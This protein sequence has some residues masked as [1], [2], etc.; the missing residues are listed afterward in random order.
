MKFVSPFTVPPS[1]IQRLKASNPANMMRNVLTACLLNIRARGVSRVF[2]SH[3]RPGCRMD[4][5][6]DLF[7]IE[8]DSDCRAHG[9]GT[10]GGLHRPTLAAQAHIKC[11]A[12]LAATVSSR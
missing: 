12:I 8:C 11:F 10:Q 7:P 6:T 3:T 4:E 2:G 5:A 1:A 9:V